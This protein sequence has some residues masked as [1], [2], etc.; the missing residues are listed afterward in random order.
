MKKLALIRIVI[1][2]MLFLSACATKC[3]NGCKKEANPQCMADMCDE[4]CEYWM[5]LNGCYNEH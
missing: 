1:C 3:A 4:C 2:M 5:G